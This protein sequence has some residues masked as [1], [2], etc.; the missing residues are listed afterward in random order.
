MAM[1]RIE[2]HHI[3]LG[4]DQGLGPFQ[5]LR[6][7]PE[8]GAGKQA[9]HAVFGGIGILLD[10]FDILDGDQ[11]LEAALFINDQQFFDAVFVEQGLGMR[12]VDADRGGDQILAGHDIVDPQAVVGDKAEVAVGDDAHQFVVISHRQPGDPVIAHDLLAHRPRSDSGVTVIGST[13]MPD[14]D[15]LTRSTS[16]AWCSMLMFL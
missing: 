15:F 11:A 8:G 1:G 7:D 5:Q 12:Q 9:A 3:D 6:T 13:I 16:L 2:Y 10:L 4:L 14:S